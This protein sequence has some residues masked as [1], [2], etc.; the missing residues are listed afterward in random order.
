MREQWRGNRIAQ[1][2]CGWG[3]R[4]PN[5]T[6]SCN[7]QVLNQH[8]CVVHMKS[9]NSKT[10]I[11]ICINLRYLRLQ[12]LKNKEN[13]KK[14]CHIFHHNFK[15]IPCYVMSE[16]SLKR[17]YFALFDDGLTLKTLKLA[18]IGFLIQTLH[19]FSLN[20]GHSLIFF[21]CLWIMISLT[22]NIQN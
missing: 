18:F 7:L 19:M 2:N 22:T 5:D 20:G 13:N 12:L 10:D 11:S 1:F 15:N 9:L 16:V 17:C 8:E 3:V 21:L 6:L 14:I 4:L